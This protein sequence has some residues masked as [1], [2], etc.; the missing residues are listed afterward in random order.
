MRLE[1][2]PVDAHQAQAARDVLIDLAPEPEAGPTEV[3]KVRWV[4]ADMSFG[5]EQAGGPTAGASPEAISLDQY[6]LAESRTSAEPSGD[7]T[8]HS[9]ATTTTSAVRGSLSVGDKVA[10]SPGETSSHHSEALLPIGPKATDGSEY[11]ACPAR[12]VTACLA[13]LGIADFVCLGRRARGVVLCGH[14]PALG[15]S[16]GSRRRPTVSVLVRHER[17]VHLGYS[18][19]RSR[20]TVL[21]ERG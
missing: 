5:Y 18:P 4:N 7:G 1:A 12:L 20:C 21:V 3:N 8:E 17:A 2:E 6:D 19:W 15:A 11:S 9:S 10:S 16:K 13:V 14:E